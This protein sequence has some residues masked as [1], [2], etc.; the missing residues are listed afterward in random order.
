ML[1]P[2]SVDSENRLKET[3]GRFAE[4]GRVGASVPDEGI[5][6]LEESLRQMEAL[7]SAEA[8]AGVMED[9]DRMLPRRE[10]HSRWTES[11]ACRKSTPRR[12]FL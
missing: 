6:A 4:S 7:W 3:E 11:A 2:V 1:G 5:A 9:Q 12:F 8:I 10:N